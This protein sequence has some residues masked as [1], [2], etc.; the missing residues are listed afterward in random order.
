[1]S[2]PLLGPCQRLKCNA[3]KSNLEL[4]VVFFG[5]HTLRHNHRFSS[6][7]AISE[8]SKADMLG[9]V[10]LMEPM[11][12]LQALPETLQ[13]FAALSITPCLSRRSSCV[14]PGL[15]H[16]VFIGLIPPPWSLPVLRNL[17]PVSSPASPHSRPH[18]NDNSTAYLQQTHTAEPVPTN[19]W[20]MA[21]QGGCYAHRVSAH[22]QGEAGGRG[23]SVPTHV[24]P[25]AS[26]DQQDFLGASIWLP[27]AALTPETRRAANTNIEQVSRGGSRVAQFMLHKKRQC[28][29]GD[30]EQHIN[31][32][33]GRAHCTLRG[34]NAWETLQCAHCAITCKC[35]D[36]KEQCAHCSMRGSN[37]W[38]TMCTWRET[39]A[40]AWV[41]M[42]NAHVAQ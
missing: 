19:D 22:V 12:V 33:Q 27:E 5:I 40:N 25:L 32:E 36:G 41:T 16:K 38:E 15:A 9:V 30:N 39:S 35:L 1:M 6:Y 3:S 18:A 24:P 7:G 20:I 17:C 26:V 4:E 23:M 11:D 13:N 14:V 34:S 42:N 28:C 8:R 21:F 31:I 37:A 29:M 2:L 10:L